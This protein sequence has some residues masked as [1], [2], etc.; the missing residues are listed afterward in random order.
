MARTLLT[1]KQVEIFNKKEFNKVVLDK[2]FETFVMH[3]TYLSLSITSIH[4]AKK[5]KIISLIAKEVKIL[6]KYLD[7]S[8]TF[9]KRKNFD[10]TEDNQSKLIY[11]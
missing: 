9:L 4:P 11:Y 1:T 8:D 5:T 10:V 2:N 3:I 6:A 7:F